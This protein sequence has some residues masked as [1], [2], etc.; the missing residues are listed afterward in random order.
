VPSASDILALDFS[1]VAQASQSTFQTADSHKRNSIFVA[2][3]THIDF[4][5][6]K[7]AVLVLIENIL[8]QTVGTCAL[9]LDSRFLN[10]KYFLSFLWYIY[11]TILLCICQEV[12]K[13]YAFF[14]VRGSVPFLSPLSIYLCRLGVCRGLWFCCLG[15]LFLLTYL[16][17]HIYRDLS[18]GNNHQS[19]APIFVQ[20][21]S[22]RIKRLG[23][24]VFEP[25]EKRKEGGRPL[26]FDNLKFHYWSIVPPLKRFQCC[27][28]IHR[29]ISVFLLHRHSHIPKQSQGHP[30]SPRKNNR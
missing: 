19:F 13:K 14:F 17:Y 25:S 26:N 18:I 11:Y 20:N 6:C 22:P 1:C 15:A 29:R 21:A 5:F 28:I 12:L 3:H 24:L 7:I 10:H 27:M 2:R 16:L 8:N 9:A 30:P 23:T 4:F